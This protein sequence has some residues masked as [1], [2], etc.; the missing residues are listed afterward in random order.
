MKG[1]RSILLGN[2]SKKG[3]EGIDKDTL[4][5]VFFL[6]LSFVLWFLNSLEKEIETDIKYPVRYANIPKDRVLVEDL[7]SKLTLYLKGPGY[8][9]MKLK[10]Y[11]SKTPVVIDISDVNYRRVPGSSSLSYYVITSGLIKNLTNQLKAECQITS[12]QPDTLYFTFDRIVSRKVRVIPD[13]EVNTDRQYF[14][15]G[16]IASEPDSVTITGPRHIVDTVK[17]VKTRKRRLTGVNETLRKNL[18]LE[19]EGLYDLSERKVSVTIPVEQFTEARLKV[20]VK[21]LNKPDSIDIKIFP[22][23]VNVKCLVALSDYK[24]IENIPFE[25]ILD[26]RK[27][28]I[29]TANKLPLEIINVP[30][31]VTSLRFTPSTVDFLIEKKIR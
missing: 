14:V 13:V 30:Y 1:Q 22:D 26:M 29:V 10:V 23:E 9:I 24:K 8:S 5:F 19:N 21:I 18:S 2:L 25:V 3:T 15:K 6:F 20:P 27:T 28:D 12:I 17:G 31:F 7:P 11:G 16:S 4:V